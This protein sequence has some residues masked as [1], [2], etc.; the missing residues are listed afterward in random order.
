MEALHSCYLFF[1]APVLALDGSVAGVNLAAGRPTYQSSTHG[2]D[3][4]RYSYKAVGSWQFLYLR[5]WNLT[6]YFDLIYS[7]KKKGLKEVQGT[8]LQKM[9]FFT[10]GHRVKTIPLHL[11]S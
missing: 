1:F 6:A 2:A 3:E 9:D 4:T 8:L 10:S 5:S 7:I 11:E